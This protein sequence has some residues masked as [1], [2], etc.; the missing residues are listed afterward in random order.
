MCAPKR[1]LGTRNGNENIRDR[2]MPR[3]PLARAPILPRVRGA[4]PRN[5]AQPLWYRLDFGE[6]DCT[7]TGE[8]ARDAKLALVEAALMAGDEPL[9]AK[10]LVLAAG[11]TDVAEA[12]QLIERLSDLYDRDGTAFQV[13]E[14]AGGY[15]LLTRP[16]YHPWVSRLRRAG[17]EVRLTPAARE[18]L[19][20]V[21]YRQPINRAEVEKIRGVQC[22]EVLHQL[23]EKGLVRIAGREETLG[24]P[25][26]YGTTRRFLRIY[27][28]KSLKDL[29]AA[30]GFA[31]RPNGDRDAGGA[32]PSAN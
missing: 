2:E 31:A 21:A 10:R 30:E 20:I 4:F 23:M 5:R 32:Q 17:A 14:V 8:L 7:A 12:R 6:D 25:V 3:H 15:Q 28:L 1:S 27:G 18:T 13:E 26:L 9:P 19:A 22:G 11:L 29:P 24:R 16:E